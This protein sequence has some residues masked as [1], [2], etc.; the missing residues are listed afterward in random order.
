M[1]TA[2]HDTIDHIAYDEPARTVILVI[3]EDRPWGEHGLLL[4]DLQWKMNTYFSYVVDGRLIAD[5]PALEG[6]R[7]RIELRCAYPPGDRETEFIDIVSR[8]HLK[9]AEID[10]RWAPIKASVA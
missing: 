1:T 6:E 7:V 9:P 2:D 3:V 10:F 5:Y 8:E 4:P